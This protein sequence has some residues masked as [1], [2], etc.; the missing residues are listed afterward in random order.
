MKNKLVSLYLVSFL[1]GVSFLQALERPVIIKVRPEEIFDV[2]TNPNYPQ[3]TIAYFRVDWSF[4]EPEM[5]KY[6]LPM[7]DIALRTA[8]GITEPDRKCDIWISASIVW[9]I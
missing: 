9:V 3:T 7:I 1:I 4:M 5:G 6:N 8:E 2:F